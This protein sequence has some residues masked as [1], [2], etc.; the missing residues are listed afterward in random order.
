MSTRAVPPSESAA[1]EQEPIAIVGIGCRLP[2]GVEGPE[3]FWD[4][5]TAGDD[6][7]VDIPRDRWLADKF[8]DRNLGPGTSRVR[9][10]G[11]LQ[12]P[13][14][15]FDAGFFE[16]SPREA[17]HI[18][19][20]Q[21]LLL[22]VA[23]EAVEDSGT[24][25]E[26]LSGTSTGV[27][28]GGFTLDYGQLQFSGGDRS[29]VSAHTATGVV[30]TMLANRISHAFDLLGPSVALDTACSSSLVAVHLACQSLWSGESTAALAGGVNLMLTPNFTVA[31]S[32]GGFLSPTSQSH[33]FDATADGYVRGEGAGVVVLKRLS[34]ALSDGDRVYAV[35]R[36]TAVSQDGRTNGITVPR[37]ESQQQA[38]RE[39]LAR[40]GVDASSVVYVEAHGTS[41][42][43]GD[44]VEVGAIGEV[45]GRGANRRADEVCL[46]A[47][48]KANIGHLEA[49]AGVTGLIKTALC[50]HH[51]M[52]PPQLHLSTV[53]PNIDL[54]SLRLRIPVAG[55]PLR[56]RDGVVRA[57]TN[58]FGFGGTNAHVVLESAPVGNAFPALADTR[59]SEPLESVFPLAARSTAALAALA[60]HYAEAMESIDHTALGAVAAHRRTHHRQARLAVV[61]NSVQELCDGLDS[62]RQGVPHPAVHLAEGPAVP[63]PLAFVY[64]GMGPQWWGMGRQLLTGNRVFAEAIERCDAGLRPYTGWSL[65]DELMADEAHSRMS[66][67]SVA[68]PANFALQVALTELW[69][70]LGIRPD[71]VIGHSAGEIAAAYAAG[72]LTFEDAVQVIYERARLQQLTVGQG[73]LAAA[74]ISLERALELPAVRRGRLVVAA[75]NSPESVALVGPTADL[76]ELLAALEAE[77]VF[78]RLVDGDVPF[79][80]PMMDPLE[81]ELRRCLAGLTPSAPTVPLYSSVGGG[82]FGGVDHDVRNT[83]GGHNAEYWWRNVRAPVRFADAAMAMIDDGIG[84]FVEIGPQPVLGRSLADCLSARGRSGSTVASLRRNAQDGSVMAHACAE[85]YVLGYAPDWTVFH[86]GHADAS[87]RLPT[88]PWQRERYWKE[89]E[90]TRLD[91][92]GELDHPLLGARRD[93]PT[94]S[95]RRYLDGSRPGYLAD[96]TVMGGN[97]FPGAGYIEMALAGGRAAFGASPCV[98]EQIRFEAPTV[99]SAGPVYQL[100]TTVDRTTGRVEIHGR[101][102]GSKSWVRHATARLSP[103]AVSVPTVDLAAVRARCTDEWDAQTCY[104][105]FER[106]GFDYGPGFQSVERLWLGE[107]EALGLLSRDAVARNAGVDHV[108]DPIVLD[109]CFQMLL[110]LIGVSTEEPVMMMPVGVDRIVVNGRIDGALW[111]HATADTSSASGSVSGGELAGD[112]VLLDEDGRV[113]ATIQGFRVRLLGPGRQ[114]RPQLGSTWLH[115]VV[116]EV[117]DDVPGTVA[118]SGAGR[119]L[120]FADAAGISDALADRL[121]ALGH[122]AVL[123]RPGDEFA[124]GQDEFRIRP[125]QRADLDEVIRQVAGQADLP[126]LGIVHAWSAGARDAELTADRLATAV[127]QGPQLLLNLVQALEA[128]GVSWP[129][130]VV[131]VG[132]QPVDGRVWA[133]GLLQSPLWG[134]TRV[135]H[136]ESL[137]LRARIMD[138]DP[139]RPLDDVPSLLAELLEAD[140]DEDQIAWRKGE[141]RVARLHPSRRASGSVPFTYR[142]DAGY[143]ITGGLGALGLVFARHLA[144]RGA[145]RIV[146]LGRTPLPP[147]STWAALAPDHPQR[148]QVDAVVQVEKLGAVVETASLDV[149]DPAALRDFVEGRRRSALPPIH[150]VVHSAGAVNDQIL[151]RM[152]REQFDSVL[153][154]KTLGAWALHE[155]LADEPLDFF[156]VFSSVGSVV[157]TAGQANYAAGNAFL[158]GFAHYRRSRGL[159]ALSINW[160]AWDAGMIAHLGLQS[161]YQR[162][163]IDLLTE[164]SGTALF[165]E[166]LGSGETQQVAVSAHWPTVISNYQIVPRLIRHLGQDQHDAAEGASRESVAD[167]LA[168]A[169]AGEHR[170]IIAD[171]CTEIIG[172]VL[173]TPPDRLPRQEALNRLGL[174]SMLAVELRIRFEQAFGVTPKVVFLLDGATVEDIAEVVHQERPIEETAA[175]PESPDDL[176]ELLSGLDAESA[177]ALLADIEHIAMKGSELS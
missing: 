165:D 101:A 42:P 123:V 141:R 18:D 131:T 89:S 51:R 57:A 116:W 7:I 139:D 13:V 41:T 113:A 135:L 119:W 29:N 163:G 55:E 21:R 111:V 94:P 79:H 138:L 76:K 130:D 102:A 47:S 161:F 14:D 124:A 126:V 44:P 60:G 71:A 78:C 149:T 48:V 97:L 31:A 174:D 107:G 27:F 4:L 169:P 157:A 117:Q 11:F 25:L 96:H 144:A 32:Q 122:R 10:G 40:A 33:P 90:A 158:D 129:L 108:V 58:S 3:A 84:V 115:E 34:E 22:E 50:V 93:T 156:V 150:G 166:L 54:E 92:L 175:A 85:L 151:S 87:L 170:A 26:R 49:A 45:Y 12:C 143:L 140:P 104:S 77:G 88:Y 86:P 62:L 75:V 63:P 35:I 146:L 23:W 118:T 64:T 121:A 2:G 177:E 105:V 152:T 155:G 69:A 109:G 176:A 99:L 95:W 30:M 28:I 19:P 1:K 173:R 59:R 61:T 73:R 5:L 24:P 72:C 43:V 16:I 37:S 114:S 53:N 159:P 9:R 66:Q 39:A 167:R 80:S 65:V 112:A 46:L 81:D 67:T 8:Y 98:V 127:S 147:R 20:Q 132:A 162:R 83:H 52:V 56:E 68:Q 15:E 171:A 148:E 106:Q 100:D 160:G 136:Q 110:P 142:P 17:E 6:A 103:P 172:S 154:P 70:S 36:G 145:R 125:D 168:A 153:R 82:R 120:V 38:M 133:A 164:A 134:M 128:Q 137:P 74:A 91:R